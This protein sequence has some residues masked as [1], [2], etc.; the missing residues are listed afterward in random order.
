[1]ALISQSLPRVIGRDNPWRRELRLD[2][3]LPASVLGPV[4][5]FALPRLASICRFDVIGSHL[6]FGASV[7]PHR[8]GIKGCKRARILLQKGLAI[9][10]YWSV[11]E[12]KGCA[13]GPDPGYLASLSRGL[14]SAA[15][16]A[17]LFERRVR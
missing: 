2:L 7:A 10:R 12:S 14:G 9:L 16:S 15:V 1:M 8:Q 3:V 5:R 13:F 6:L 11:T 17:A 4:L